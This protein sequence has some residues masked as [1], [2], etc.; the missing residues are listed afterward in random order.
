MI[1]IPFLLLHLKDYCKFPFAQKNVFSAKGAGFNASPP[2]DGFA[3]ANLGQRP[4]VYRA[5]K[6]RE[7]AERAIHARR[8]FDP[9]ARLKRAFSAGA[10]GFP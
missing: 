4:R 9:S 3:V 5:Q 6:K 1:V 2:E 7:S 10:S 8:D